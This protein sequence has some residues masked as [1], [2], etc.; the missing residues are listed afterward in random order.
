MEKK[1]HFYCGTELEEL[2]AFYK[3]HVHGYA[4]LV[5][6]VLGAVANSLNVIVFSRKEMISPVN[7]VLG[8]LAL[9]DLVVLLDYIPFVWYMYLIP[10]HPHRDHYTYIWAVVVLWH[11]I[12][13]QIFHTIANWQAVVLAVW[14]Y[15]AVVHPLRNKRW[16]D[17]MATRR[18]VL[19]G[20]LVCPLLC[21]PLFFSCDIQ[22]KTVLLNESGYVAKNE[23]TGI[24]STLYVV[25]MK[26]TDFLWNFNFLTYS[27]LF[28][29]VPSVAL[30]I[31]SLRLVGFA[32]KAHN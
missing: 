20:F 10:N 16:C 9:A 2:S 27:V 26:K 8:G 21:L 11:S 19:S 5:I 31:L 15:I 18:A 22:P 25:S 6:C 32:I 29:L 1:N 23:S 4:S 13:S 12:F 24:N 3:H 30:T 17:T 14:R 7:T 28:K